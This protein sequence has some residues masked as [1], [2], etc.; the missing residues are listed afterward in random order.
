MTDMDEH[1]KLLEKERM[2]VRDLKENLTE[3]TED[4]EQ[5]SSGDPGAGG[6]IADAGSELFE[7]SRDLSIV[8]DLDAQLADIEHAMARLTNG[9]YGTCEACGGP[10]DAERLAARPAARFCLEDQQEAERE[11]HVR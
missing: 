8:E 9:S 5:Q 11:V 3:A 4:V 10:I 1:R 6:H 2:R 7:R